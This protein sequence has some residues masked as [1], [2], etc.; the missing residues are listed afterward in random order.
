[1][2]A[3]PLVD[4]ISSLLCQLR[5]GISLTPIYLPAECSPGE[6]LFLAREIFSAAEEFGEVVMPGLRPQLA[7]PL[8]RIPL[9]KGKV[10][11]PLAMRLGGVH[12][13][14]SGDRRRWDRIRRKY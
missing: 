6:M 2:P 10:K 3:S 13:A 11:L 9:T 12:R 1:M 4:A 7:F 5:V 14:S 8:P